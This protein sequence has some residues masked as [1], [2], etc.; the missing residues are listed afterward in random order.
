MG[1]EDYPRKVPVYVWIK[2]GARS[3]GGEKETIC[4]VSAYIIM[5]DKHFTDEHFL[6]L[7]EALLYANGEGNGDLSSET[8]SAAGPHEY[9]SDSS[10]PYVITGK[11][12]DRDRHIPKWNCRPAAPHRKL[13]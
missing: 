4:T 12:V 2:K 10:A 11:R 5:P 9:P 1:E 6:T 13:S 8:R 7:Q 3:A